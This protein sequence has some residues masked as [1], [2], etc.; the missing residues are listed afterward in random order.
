M[1]VQSIQ[2]RSCPFEEYLTLPGKSYSDIKNDGKPFT[3]P[4]RKMSLGT[5]V[6]QYLLTP[7]EYNHEDKAIVK[8]LAIALKNKLGVLIQFLQAEQAIQA[9]FVH[10]GL[11]LKYRGRID[12]GIRGRLIVDI[13]VSEMPL[14]KAID[15][16]GYN[17]QLSGYALGYEA[18]AALIIAIH[19]VTKAISMANIPV[20]AGWWEM[21]VVKYGSPC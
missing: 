19:P 9:D 5:K 14:Q 20:S 13:K 12:L 7:E 10:E 21:Q 16:F 17:Y 6:H 2:T 8:P 11:V 4:T 18:R 3:G 15:Y 1:L